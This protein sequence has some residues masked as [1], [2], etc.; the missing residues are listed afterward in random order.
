M[1]RKFD[2]DI[3]TYT[4]A[5]MLVSVKQRYKEVLLCYRMYSN[6]NVSTYVH[7]KSSYAHLIIYAVTKLDTKRQKHDSTY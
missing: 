5:T 2:T 3:V 1:L 6:T 7:V 4:D